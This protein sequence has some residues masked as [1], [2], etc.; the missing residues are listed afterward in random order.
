MSVSNGD[1]LCST[2]GLRDIVISMETDASSEW[3]RAAAL[4][5]KGVVAAGTGRGHT[6]WEPC[7]HAHRPGRKEDPA[8]GSA[9]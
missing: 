8:E 7:L 9:C 5:G 3:V 2:L 4:G 1:L 6:C